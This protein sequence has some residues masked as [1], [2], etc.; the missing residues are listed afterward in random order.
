MNPRQEFRSIAALWFL[1]TA[2][3]LPAGLRAAGQT[4]AIG[5]GTAAAEPE[6]SM[7]I[8][9][10]KSSFH[11]FRKG[12]PI[13]TS[14]TLFWGENWSWAGGDDSFKFQP[15]G[16]GKY[17]VSGGVKNLGLTITGKIEPTAPNVLR[18]DFVLRADRAFPKVI[19][20]GWQWDL[21]P[22][23]P[24][25]AEKPADPKLLPD[26][27]GWTWPVGEGQAVTLRIEGGNPRVYFEQGQKSKIRTFFVSN[28][29]EPGTMRYRVTLEVPEGGKL[30]PADIERYGPETPEKWFHGA[31]LPNAS[32]VDLSFLNRDDRP[33]GRRG[34]IRAEGDRLV[35]ADGTMA[36]FWGSN[37]TA[38]T[39]FS[40]PREYVPR[41]AH[42]MAQLG[43]NLMRLHHHDSEWVDPNIFGRKAPSTLTLDPTSLDMLDWW[44]KCLKD[45]GIY[46]W[47]DMQVGRRLTNRDGVT[48][49]FGEIARNQKGNPAPFN[50]YNPQVQSLMKEFQTAYLSHRNSYTR[51]AY[52]DDPAI[53]GVLITNENDL[54]YHGG[55][56]FLPDHKNSYH[57][58]LWKAS[59]TRF[60]REHR[61]PLDKIWQT[62]VAGPSKIYLAQAEHEFN[63]A[64][65]A[66][67][68]Q[69]G[70]KTPIATTN[71]W[72]DEPLFSLPSLTDG[73]MIDVHSYGKSESL[74]RN[75]RYEEQFL[76]WIAMGQV[77][78]KPLTI[79]EWNVPY[80]AL[81]RFVA[82]IWIASIATLQGWD[83]PMLYGY[84]Q[85]LAPPNGVDQWTTYY[86][87]AL[88]AIMPAAALIYRAGHVSPAKKTY[89]LKLD[90]AKFFGTEINPRTSAAIRTLAEQSKLTVAMPETPELPW[91]KPS[92]PAKDAIIVTDPDRDFLPPGQTFVKSDTGEITRDWRQG[93]L[94]IDT[95]KSQAVSGWIG[96]KRIKT[97]DARF[98]TRTRKAVVALSSVD[99]K[100]LVESHFIL[101]TAVARAVP[102]RPRK[103]PMASEPV[104]SRITLRCRTPDLELLAMGRDGH[105]VG[106]TDLDRQGDHVTFTVPTR[107][108][109]HWF[110]LKSKSRPAENG[111]TDTA[112]PARTSKADQ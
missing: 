28:R 75:P 2:L 79:T 52:K 42:R 66:D 1:T 49:G 15:L 18:M 90:A 8:E 19:G 92:Q 32:P 70:L 84:S 34:F 27:G 102:D 26:N 54:S 13:I 109:S 106:R 71:F 47:L 88:T 55:H 33:A 63:A 62:W 22:K 93:I 69:L 86:D 96:G 16:G 89:C 112:T 4:P 9:P 103:V 72:G 6:W 77:C 30:L 91:L 5:D 14:G 81:D 48:E 39:L 12:V 29:I 53:I 108:G 104:W 64:M 99:G 21:K 51:L 85:N 58:A 45:E 100:P 57:G 82:P 23:S 17:N 95:P 67:L 83:A 36:R 24:V 50:Y 35:F 60:A 38:F 3:A 74:S 76:D 80:P 111:A 40:T 61:L 73:D 56:T 43:Y 44:I 101:V 20:G 97:T 25:F 87:P 31:L 41:Q 65:I 59:Y 110:V 46:V 78:D 98:E 107:G 37:L 10:K 68:R 11:I 94:V 105:V 7:Q